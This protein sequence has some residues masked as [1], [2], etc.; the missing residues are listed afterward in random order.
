MHPHSN[1]N[2]AP[3][4]SVPLKRVG[5]QWEFFYGGDVPVQ[6]GAV[7]TLLVSESAISDEKFRQ[8]IKQQALVRVLKEGAPLLIA[9][10]DR[11]A[12]AIPE[13]LRSRINPADLPSETTRLERVHL[14]APTS[15]APTRKSLEAEAGRGGLW[16]NVKGLDTRTSSA[17]PTSCTSK[18]I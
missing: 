12:R 15:S 14:A 16:L 10:T 3:K 18:A 8:K 7:A 17:R 1:S 5:G 2:G 6:E 13:A 4:L 11:T 9:L